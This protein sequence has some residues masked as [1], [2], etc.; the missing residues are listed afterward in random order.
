MKNTLNVPGMRSYGL[1][2]KNNF[3]S[4][5]FLN[6]KIIKC[7]YCHKSFTVPIKQ[8]IKNKKGLRV[9]EECHNKLINTLRTEKVYKE[10]QELLTEERMQ[11]FY[12]VFNPF[13]EGTLRKYA[14]LY[15]HYIYHIARILAKNGLLEK[16]IINSKKRISEGRKIAWAYLRKASPYIKHITKYEICFSDLAENFKRTI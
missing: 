15:E 8:K 13:F 9:C 14:D 5:Y 10:I 7:A 2:F 11:I 1:E 12:K 16:D 4:S 6:R 3:D